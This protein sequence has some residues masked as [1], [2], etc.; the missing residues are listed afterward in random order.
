MKENTKLFEL[1]EPSQ[2]TN[3]SK[4]S[5]LNKERI[6]EILSTIYK[7]EEKNKIISE[8]NKMASIIQN[9]KTDDLSIL[10]IT[11]NGETIRF[12]KNI[13][14]EEFN[15]ILDAQTIERARYYINR[16]KKSL[17]EIKTGKINDL[18][19]NRWKEHDDILTDS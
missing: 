9:P 8:I 15:Q 7:Y 4:E 1:T 18:N 12:N 2:K 10:N 14:L 6:I 3:W 11:S 19:L 13:L 16:L 5:I 17:T